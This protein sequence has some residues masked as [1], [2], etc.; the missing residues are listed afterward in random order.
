MQCSSLA[1][2]S[3]SREFVSVSR[4]LVSLIADAIISILQMRRPIAL[5]RKKIG[6]A[7]L[8]ILSSI[9]IASHPVNDALAITPVFNQSNAKNLNGAGMPVD[10]D[11]RAD[12]PSEITTALDSVANREF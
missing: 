3:K 12:G 6:R 5:G 4:T 7:A 9:P 8:Q 2:I 11:T 10:L 1:P